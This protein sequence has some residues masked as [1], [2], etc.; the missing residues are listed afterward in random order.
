MSVTQSETPATEV[1][2]LLPTLTGDARR[3]ASR[4]LLCAVGLRDFEDSI[5]SGLTETYEEFCERLTAKGVGR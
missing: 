5:T 4:Q 3:E 2:R 1:L